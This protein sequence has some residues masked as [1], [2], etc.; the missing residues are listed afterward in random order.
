MTS[1]KPTRNA[2]TLRKLQIPWHDPPGYL[3]SRDKSPLWRGRPEPVL[4]P[5][6]A[7]SFFV[8]E[9]SRHVD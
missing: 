6:S 8:L 2:C 5:S 9:V 1:Q 3:A 4:R 7:E